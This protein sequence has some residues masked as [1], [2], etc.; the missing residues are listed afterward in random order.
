[1][2]SKKNFPHVVVDFESYYD[3]ECSA[4]TIGVEAYT[5]HPNFDAYMV[6]VYD[7]PKGSIKYVG[8]PSK[9][10]WRK[11]KNRQIVA[12]N[13][14]FDWTIFNTAR[15]EGWWKHCSK[16][17]DLGTWRDTAA[18]AAF[19]GAPRSLAGACK[20]LLGVEL[21]KGMRDWMKG[22]TFD[23][24]V[25]EGKA[26]ALAE[27]AM[28]DSIYAWKLYDEFNDLMPKEEWR[29]SEWTTTS[30][31]NGVAIDVKLLRKNISTMR[32]RLLEV[33][34]QIPWLNDDSDSKPTSP[35]ALASACRDIGIPPPKSTAK[36]STDFD[37][38]LADYAD[39]APFVKLMQEHRS[40]NRVLNV[41]RSIEMRQCD[42]ILTFSKK[43]YGA[44]TGRFSGD[45]GLNME[46][47]PREALCG[48]NIRNV[49]VAR[50]KKKL[51]IADYA[52][53]EA[54]ILLW[55]ANDTDTLELVRKGISVYEAHARQTMGWEGGKLKEENDSL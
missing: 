46:N 51:V 40:I 18:L 16:T 26:D 41:L 43:Y 30:G 33:E 49:F 28:H 17:L 15:R 20:E 29:L 44:H 13:A 4:S 24:A 12:H 55:F 9:F 36:T 19:L 32:K 1:M 48:V 10:D 5:R 37:E 7:G 38:W 22:R 14:Q 25:R 52:Q 21:S 47:F 34:E 8:H 39:K 27:Y 54:R 53:I 6:S 11:L 35:K 3:N 45:G 42:G 2:N 31:M 50:P 23:D